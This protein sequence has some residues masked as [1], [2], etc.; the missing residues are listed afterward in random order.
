MKRLVSAIMA[1]VLSAQIANA[2]QTINGR[3]ADSNNEPVAFANVVLMTG[4]SA[5]IS[6]AVSDIDGRFA[7]EQKQGAQIISISCIGYER[8]C[9]QI[10][11]IQNFGNIVIESQS[12]QL[13]E[14]TVK[15]IAPKTKLKDGAMVTT[16]EGS[17]LA[18]TGSTTRML[19]NVPGLIKGS[20]G[21]LEVI[22]RGAP[23]FYINNRK[24]RDLNELETLSPDNIKNVEVISSPGARYDATVKA[25][26]RIT[27]IVPTGE[28]FG[29]S[30]E[31]DATQGLEDFTRVFHEK[32]SFN[33]RQGGFDLFGNARFDINNRMGSEIELYTL[34]NSNHRWETDNT[35]KATQKYQYMPLNFGANYQIDN[36]NSLGAQYTYKTIMN[37]K[38]K[39]ENLIDAMCD[40]QLYDHLTMQSD[41]RTTDDFEHDMNAYFNG[42]VRGF[43]IDF[44]TD[45]VYNPTEKETTTPEVSENFEN[46]DIV[47]TNS[48]LNKLLAHKLVVGHDLWGGHI[49]VGCETSLTDRTDETSSN[50]EEFVPSVKSEAQQKAVAGFAEY[51][52]TFAEKYN[53]TAGLRYEHLNLD[54]F[55]NG[56]LNSEASTIYNELFPSAT[57]SGQFGKY[58][59]LQLAYNEKIV[60]PSYFSMSNNVT[61]VSRY[62]Q[63]IGNPTLKPTILRSAE[64]TATL[65]V[66]QVK[67]IYTHAKNHYIQYQTVNEEHPESEVLSW[68]NFDK[69]TLNLQFATQLPLGIYRPTIVYYFQKQWVDDIESNGQMLSFNKPIQGFVFNNSVELKSGWLFELNSQFVKKGGNEDYVELINRSFNVDFYVHKSLFNKAL[70][71]EA[72]IGDIFDKGTINARLY[73]QSGY[74]EQINNNDNRRVSVTVKY[75][76][77]TAK[78]KYKGTGAGNA[79]KERL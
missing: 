52:R 55:D 26:V 58:V 12:T 65:L 56:Q 2:Q 59:Q 19:S 54:F 38:D 13:D 70:D 75:K 60:R 29:F 4:D 57:F 78:S 67:A 28:G 24:V 9:K 33:Y 25:V 34:N 35:A 36:Q 48:V 16:V 3:I 23:E 7:I 30:L 46:R 27:T 49:D 63:Q 5:Y 22:G 21:G 76:F 31:S 43:N 41:A 47:T 15:A 77:N 1:T 62:L 79:E 11:E 6:G 14:V 17:T 18:R 71:I 66:V 10:S 44:N 53:L 64:L 8:F 37:R 40:G 50:L 39:A 51:K 61:Y 32:A 72:G 74:T 68:I 45:L 42:E 20:S 69:P 73:N